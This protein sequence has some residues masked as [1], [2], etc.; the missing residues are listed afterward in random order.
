MEVSANNLNF[1][2]EI[3]ENTTQIFETFQLK[4]ETFNLTFET[5]NLYIK[6]FNAS[7]YLLFYYN[8]LCLVLSGGGVGTRAYCASCTPD[9]IAHT[10]PLFKKRKGHFKY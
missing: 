1:Q 3:L 2:L 10:V 9:A 6:T 8:K 7:I 4:T 5:L